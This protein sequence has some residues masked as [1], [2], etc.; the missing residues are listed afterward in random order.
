MRNKIKKIVGRL[1]VV[2]FVVSIIEV[3]LHVWGILYLNRFYIENKSIQKINRES[4]TVLCLGESSTVG[5]W[6][7][8]NDSY[9]AKLE[10]MLR[11]HFDSEN[12]Y[13]I[14]PPHVG[15]NTS[16]MLNRIRQYIKLYRPKV[17]VM[18]VGCNN[19]WSLAESNIIK[20]MPSNSINAI[21]M[22]MFIFFNR[23]HLFKLS[24]YFYLRIKCKLRISVEGLNF[25]KYIAGAPQHMYHLPPKWVLNCFNYNVK[26][27]IRLWRYDVKSMIR[28]AKETNTPII[29]MTYPIPINVPIEEFVSVA[30]EEDIILIRNDLDFEALSESGELGYYIFSRDNWHPTGRGYAVVA[31]NVFNAIVDNELVKY[32]DGK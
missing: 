30:Q 24:R 10:R 8:K 25:K 9:P 31:Q 4:Q 12:I 21:R 15:Q 5:I 26:K 23:F 13:V 32:S 14:V 17:I 22:K 2:V 18:M 6:V 27:F 11:L 20:F 28:I 7:S 19:H 3:T 16:Q 29:L 1:L